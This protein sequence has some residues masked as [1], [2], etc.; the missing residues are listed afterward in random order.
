[1]VN[2]GQNGGEMISHSISL[3]YILSWEQLEKDAVDLG[4]ME[5]GSYVDF[6]AK[7]QLASK[8]AGIAQGVLVVWFKCDETTESVISVGEH[9][10]EEV[11]LKAKELLSKPRVFLIDGS[12][13]TVYAFQPTDK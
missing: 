5:E 2:S 10:W 9:H 3:E 7:M 1:L 8:I 13:F 12:R 6:Q 11:K 4:E